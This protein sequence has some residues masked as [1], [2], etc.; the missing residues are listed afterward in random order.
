[1]RSPRNQSAG[2]TLQCFTPSE[3]AVSHCRVDAGGTPGEWVEAAVASSG[4]PTV[5]YF[6]ASELGR[7]PL[8]Q[9][10]RLAGRIAV[11]TGARVLTV[12]CPAVRRGSR[13]AVFAGVA[14][15]RWLLAEGCGLERTAF[16][17]SDESLAT[18]ILAAAWNDG[19]PLPVGGVRSSP[20]RKM[21]L[22]PTEHDRKGAVRPFRGRRPRRWSCRGTNRPGRR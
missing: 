3:M 6:H 1:M 9:A 10:R 22:P 17:S 18:A 8:D 14:A 5:V 19:L 20:G 11:V 15:Y 21:S 2:R 12:G 4:Q 16:F 7:D 13:S